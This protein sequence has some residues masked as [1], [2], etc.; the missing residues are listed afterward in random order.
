ME[1]DAQQ[2]H[3][4]VKTPALFRNCAYSCFTVLLKVMLRSQDIPLAPWFFAQSRGGG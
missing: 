4:L 3:H 2:L 1:E